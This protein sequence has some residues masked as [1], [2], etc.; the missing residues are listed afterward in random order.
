VGGLRR[1]S[2]RPDRPAD[3]NEFVLIELALLV[4][5]WRIGRWSH[6][7]TPAQ[8]LAF[9]ANTGA[10]LGLLDSVAETRMPYTDVGSPPAVTLF[11]LSFAVACARTDQGLGALVAS[12]SYGG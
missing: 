4:L 11:V 5:D 10:I 3:G 1:S 9:T 2:C 7:V 6:R 8:L 12:S